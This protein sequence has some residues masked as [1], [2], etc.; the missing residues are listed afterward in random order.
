[1]YLCELIFLEKVYINMQICHV[2]NP[3]DIPV[4]SV[5]ERRR[6]GEIICFVSARARSKRDNWC[7]RKLVNRDDVTSPGG[8]D[9][10]NVQESS[11]LRDQLQHGCQVYGKLENC[12]Q[13]AAEC[14]QIW[15]IRSLFRLSYVQFILSVKK[16]INDRCYY[17]V[18]KIEYCIL[19]ST[20]RVKQGHSLWLLFLHL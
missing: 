20:P 2:Y 18:S 19:R 8:G 4:H 7:N 6:S 16:R 10:R 14:G 12:G 3:P 1:M 9:V 15:P 13:V 5:K 17:Y 11:A